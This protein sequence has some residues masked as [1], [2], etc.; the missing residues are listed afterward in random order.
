MN[1]LEVRLNETNEYKKGNAEVGGGKNVLGMKKIKSYY[2][3][4]DQ[5][6]N[7]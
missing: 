7:R 4:I 3:M 1:V 6:L 5:T 2:L